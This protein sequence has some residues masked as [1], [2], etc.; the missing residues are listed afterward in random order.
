MAIEGVR[1]MHVTEGAFYTVS[2]ITVGQRP[3]FRP[4]SR[5]GRLIKSALTLLSN[6]N[7]INY[8]N[9]KR[10]VP[11]PLITVHVIHYAQLSRVFC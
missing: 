3:K 4:Y 7:K 6:L 2:I 5:D 8:I 9:Y 11:Y 10:R 1:N